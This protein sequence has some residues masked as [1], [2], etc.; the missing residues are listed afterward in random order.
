MGEEDEA[1]LFVLVHGL[2]G[3]PTHM[4]TVEQALKHSLAGVCHER[5]VTMKPLSFRFWKT[6]DGINRCAEK[7]IAEILYEIETLKQKDSCKV[8]KISIIGYSL[9]GL[10]SRYVVGSLYEMEFFQEV[11]PMFFCT[12]ATPHVGVHFFRNN[13]FDKTANVVGKYILGVTG[14]QL[15]VADKGR[16]LVQMSDP[17]SIFYKGL[18]CFEK[19]LLLA[20]IKNDRSVAF[21]T[22]FITPHSPFDRW[23]TLKVKYFKDL[24]SSR[25][26]GITVRPKFVD[27]QRS[28]RVEPAEG[29]P[30]NSQE[31]TSIFRR[32]RILRYTVILVAASI[33]VPFYIPMI[34]CISLYV[35]WYSIVKVKLLSDPKNKNHWKEVRSA[36]YLGGEV[37]KEHA[38]RGEERRK[39]RINLA[40]KDSFKGETSFFTEH[41][42]ENVLYAESRLHDKQPEFVS[43]SPDCNSDRETKT[44]ESLEIQQLSRDNCDLS[45]CEKAKEKKRSLLPSFL[46][47]QKLID[48]DASVNDSIMKTHSAKL[49]VR[50][51]SQYPLFTEDTKLDISS[52]QSTI[53]E[54]LNKLSWE[55]IA[56][57]HDLF[58][59]HDGIVAR[60]GERTNPKGTS[61]VYLW[62]SILRNHFASASS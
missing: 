35:S 38:Q 51:Y 39:E 41:G 12:F 40:H 25:I 52:D 34:L 57:Y 23:N 24:P 47:K 56:V 14:F 29:Q 30:I 50:D 53:I 22:S 16:L 31:A 1:H 28:R 43:D 27:L 46:R 45:D 10:I 26:A 54:N 17:E 20:N 33:L 62:V 59:A 48:I 61:T 9:G 5:I 6:Y 4:L 60:R 18:Q 19:R 49:S 55:K 8:T 32:N 3:S 7:V 15:F 58:N 13:L 42:M 37:N 36:V 44:D 11:A 2:W 21:Y